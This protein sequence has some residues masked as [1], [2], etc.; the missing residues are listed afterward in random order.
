MVDRASVSGL[1]LFGI[2]CPC[3]GGIEVWAIRPVYKQYAHS[4]Y[5][6]IDT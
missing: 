6:R 4:R 3:C 1:G 5:L 2:P